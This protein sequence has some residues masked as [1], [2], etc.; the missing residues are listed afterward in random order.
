[1][2]L[3]I[4]LYIIYL[5]TYLS[6]LVSVLSHQNHPSDQPATNLIPSET[7]GQNSHKGQAWHNEVKDGSH[8]HVSH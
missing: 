8:A 5:F 3:S 6:V 4:H 2:F 7:L 1:M